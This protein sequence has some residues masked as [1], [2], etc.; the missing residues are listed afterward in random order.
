MVDKRN[1]PYVAFIIDTPLLLLTRI[2][3]TAC[4]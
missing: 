2:A 3:T 4:C 1:L